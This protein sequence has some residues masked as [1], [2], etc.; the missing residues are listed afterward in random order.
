MRRLLLSTELGSQGPVGV[1]H[2]MTN[3]SRELSNEDPI[4]RMVQQ[5]MG[6]PTLDAGSASGTSHADGMPPHLAAMLGGGSLSEQQLPHRTPYTYV[7]KVLHAVSALLL[8]IYVLSSD[9]FTGSLTSRLRSDDSAPLSVGTLFW[10]FVTV[11]LGLQAARYLLE[12]VRDEIGTIATLAKILPPP[13]QERLLLAGRYSVIWTT[14]T[15][16]AMIV[17]WSLGATVWWR[18]GLL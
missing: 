3:Q 1:N 16:D 14:F 8:G 11:E 2:P 18:G 6:V 15:D 9:N 4:T 12:G 17:V 5:M 13:W 10:I 7:W